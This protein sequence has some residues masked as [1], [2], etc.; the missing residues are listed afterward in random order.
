MGI[1]TK[2]RESTG[3][4]LW[5]LVLAFGGLWVLQDSGAL[6]NIGFQQRQNVAVV[7]D[8]PI[9]YQEYTQALEQE[10]RAYQQR[11]GEPASQAIRDQYADVIYDRLVENKLR[12]REMDRLGITVTDAEVRE[13][14]MGEN[15][16]PIVAQLFPDGE[17]GVNRAQLQ[18]V[19]DNPE[20][21]ADLIAIEDY[22][23]A[24]R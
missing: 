23:R 15:P 5:I 20:A 1:M 2:M 19:V 16:D 17:G 13:M 6:D 12:E 21:T 10:V 22:L 4:V 11:S 3:V 18:S 9:S 24:K 14:F 8:E 7:N